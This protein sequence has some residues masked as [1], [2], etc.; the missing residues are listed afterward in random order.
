M[1][2]ESFRVAGL[3]EVRQGRWWL[4]SNWWLQ[5]RQRVSLTALPSQ[6][7]PDLRLHIWQSTQHR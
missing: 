7:Q 4:E 2:C 5:D 6:L 3:W 1:T